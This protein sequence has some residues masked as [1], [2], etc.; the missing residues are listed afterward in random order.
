MI[1][2]IKY[3]IRSTTDRQLLL[4]LFIV[5][6]TLQL[7]PSVSHHLTPKTLLIQSKPDASFE[8]ILLSGIDLN[9]MARD[10][11]RIDA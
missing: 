9:C 1:F 3:I 11:S 7:H 6:L 2:M 4:N 5:H 10:D 8:D